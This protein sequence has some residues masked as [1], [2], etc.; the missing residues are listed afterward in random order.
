MTTRQ[1]R[2]CDGC[3]K[4]IENNSITHHGAY[5]SNASAAA[6]TQDWHACSA[7]CAAKHLRV[8]AA[9]VETREAE[10]VEREKAAAAEVAQSVERA[11]KEQAGRAAKR[12]TPQSS[13]Q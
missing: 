7:A 2:V 9:A 13:E 3:G 4:E 12:L 11:N 6:G 10:R 5:F 8:V 1:V